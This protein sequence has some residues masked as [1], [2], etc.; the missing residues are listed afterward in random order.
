MTTNK[1]G[2]T[3][4]QASAAI[5]QHVS[6]G[7]LAQRTWHKKDDEGR[8]IACLLGAMHPSVKAPKDCNGDL[9]PMWLAELT[10]QLFDGIPEESARDVGERYGILV[11]QWHVLSGADW[12]ALLTKFLCFTID[13]A[14]DAARPVAE[15]QPYWA[16]VAAACPGMRQNLGGQ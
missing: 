13:T 1:Y 4:A 6:E 15:G 10:P 8:E 9:M 2:I 3:H 12:E 7:R 5:L 16:R 14:L 11:G